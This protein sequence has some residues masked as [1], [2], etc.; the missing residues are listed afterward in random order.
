MVNKSIRCSVNNCHYWAKDN[1]CSAEQIMV[2]SDKMG[3]TT[4]HTFNA[5]QASEFPHTP[6]GSS[7]ETC[8]KTFITRDKDA[9]DDGIHKME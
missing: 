6:V 4:P 8:C 2:S 1:Y 3:D 7:M 5:V 9:R